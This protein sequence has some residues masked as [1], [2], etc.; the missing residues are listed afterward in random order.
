MAL[1]AHLSPRQFPRPQFRAIVTDDLRRCF[2][3]SGVLL[4]VQR[5]PQAQ[6]RFASQ[7]GTWV[8]HVAF[9]QTRL[10][11]AGCSR[12]PGSWCC[13]GR[14]PLV[15][16]GPTALSLLRPRL[17]CHPEQS[18]PLMPSECHQVLRLRRFWPAPE[19]R[20]RC[21]LSTAHRGPH[22][23]SRRREPHMSHHSSDKSAASCLPYHLTDVSPVLHR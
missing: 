9:C 19:T 2:L 7:V 18:Q 20:S 17:R 12:P 4:S 23:G 21:N 16:R 8:W 5:C 22:Q 6:V 11:P 15:G 3:G 1:W 13:V 10:L 14:R